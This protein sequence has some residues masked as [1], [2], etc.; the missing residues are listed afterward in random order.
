MNDKFSLLFSDM[1]KQIFKGS[2]GSLEFDADNTCSLEFDQN[3][4][5]TFI[6]SD[7]SLYCVA[8]LEQLYKEPLKLEESAERLSKSIE[9]FGT[10][11]NNL[12]KSCAFKG[13]IFES[14]DIDH[15]RAGDGEKSVQV[16]DKLK[17]DFEEFKR[18]FREKIVKEFKT[19]L[20]SFLLTIGKTREALDI[21]ESLLTANFAWQ[22]TK[23]CTLAIE[24]G[25]DR[26]VLSRSWGA[27]D[28]ITVQTLM[29]DI[30]SM[31]SAAEL[32]Q[33]KL[34]GIKDDSIEKSDE[35]E[36]PSLGN[37]EIAAN[38]YASV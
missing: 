3:I 15:V 23:G 16:I 31:V 22:E 35:S 30:E 12:E 21:I 13:Q 25:S 4:V 14:V 1:G 37:S 28:D 27:G 5:L 33:N 29:T 19:E 36:L 9:Y 24:P 18:T 34:R 6:N 32:C 2:S 17:A 38:P 11:I 8:Y 20:Q 26:V 7:T 10:H